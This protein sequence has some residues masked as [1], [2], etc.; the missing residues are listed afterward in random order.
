MR[1]REEERIHLAGVK[2]SPGFV[3][4]ILEPDFHLSLAQ[5]QRFC[6]IRAFVAGQISENVD[7]SL[8]HKT[9]LSYTNYFIKIKLKALTK[10]V[11][12]V[13]FWVV[14]EA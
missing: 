10:M 13:K 2:K 14:L 7:F 4:T 5:V 6:Q 1:M 12:R 8:T 3:S 11:K 9:S